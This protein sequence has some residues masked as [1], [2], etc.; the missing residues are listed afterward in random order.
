M[1]APLA[2]IPEP[3]CL[4][5]A[6]RCWDKERI[7]AERSFQDAPVWQALEAA[8]Q[9][10]ALHQRVL[11]D[12]RLHAFL[13]S[14]Q[15]FPLEPARLVGRFAV[16]GR[17]LGQSGR[18]ALYGIRLAPLAPLDA[19]APEAAAGPQGCLEGQIAIGLAPCGERFRQGLL[20]AHFRERWRRL[21]GQKGGQERGQGGRG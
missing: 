7:D 19:G 8:A 2:P 15:R 6:V 11:A 4:L 17:V 1:A 3:F 12:F 9:A 20:E 18:S 5:D 21:A 13:L 14:V 16:H 10:C